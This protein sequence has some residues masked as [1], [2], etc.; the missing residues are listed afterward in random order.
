MVEVF[1][2]ILL[3]IA[4]TTVVTVVCA[5]VCTPYIL[6][7]YIGKTGSYWSLVGNAYCHMLRNCLEFG[8]IFIL[9]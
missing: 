6:I 3:S 1:A 5:V 9:P 2:R 4:M 7:R 8:T